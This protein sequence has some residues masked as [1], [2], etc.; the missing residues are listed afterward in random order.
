M[1]RCDRAV[2]LEKKCK[3]GRQEGNSHLEGELGRTAWGDGTQ[4]APEVD[5]GREGT[6]R[7]QHRRLGGGK[8][9][10]QGLHFILAFSK[11]VN[12][13]SFVS[14]TGQIHC[15]SELGAQCH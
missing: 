2:K 7:Q 15:A 10:K 8:E 1:V 14:S 9:N 3:S 11:I 13:E 5:G 12:G 6:R 4:S